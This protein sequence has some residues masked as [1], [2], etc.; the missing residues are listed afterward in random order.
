MMTN[1]NVKNYLWGYQ[2]A[3]DSC[4]D[5]QDDHE[6]L[7]TRA[8]A[9]TKMISDMP[10]GSTYAG[11]QE[12]MD[13]INEAGKELTRAIRFQAEKKIEI[14]AL[15]ESIEDYRIERVLTELYI[16]GKVRKEVAKIIGYDVRHV[17]RLHLCGIDILKDV[18]NCP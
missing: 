8:T 7:W 10:K 5:L 16:K 9:M 6:E 12:I 4:K 1:Q 18:L 14:K 3:C 2:R 13:E 11:F 15:I 17:D